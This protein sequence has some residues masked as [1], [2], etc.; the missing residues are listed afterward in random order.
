MVLAMV[1]SVMAYSA[2]IFPPNTAVQAWY[3][4]TVDEVNNVVTADG[5]QSPGSHPGTFGQFNVVPG[6]FE[7]LSYDDVTGKG[8]KK[9]QETHFAYTIN[10]NNNWGVFDQYVRDNVNG[11]VSMT[12]QSATLLEG[13]VA[14]GG[15]TY[16]VIVDQPTNSFTVTL[17][18]TTDGNPQTGF[19]QQLH[20]NGRGYVMAGTLMLVL[21]PD[22]T[23]QSF[24]VEEWVDIGTYFS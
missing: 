8:I 11:Q 18:P 24:T 9:I 22:W 3:E 12:V 1:S 7:Q 17:M 21:D 10:E 20:A 5:T 15:A 16:H 19:T 2:V 23:A 4:V 14:F 13:D 6:G